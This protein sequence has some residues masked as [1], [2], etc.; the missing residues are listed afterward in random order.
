[1]KQLATR[2]SILM[3]VVLWTLRAVAQPDAEIDADHD[4]LSVYR[5]VEVEPATPFN[6]LLWAS[7]SIIKPDSEFARTPLFAYSISELPADQIGAVLA[8]SVRGGVRIAI[9]GHRGSDSG[10]GHSDV[11]DARGV[12]IANIADAERL[13]TQWPT[14]RQNIVVGDNEFLAFSRPLHGREPAAEFVAPTRLWTQSDLQST[15]PEGSSA[16]AD[17]PVR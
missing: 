13:S 15:A 3:I 9:V 5:P 6:K 16:L 1:M 2:V 8:A 10:S 12:H 4:L 17:N 11:Y 7:I 14:F